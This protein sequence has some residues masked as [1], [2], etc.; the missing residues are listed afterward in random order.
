MSLSC[1]QPRMN[2]GTGPGRCR[3]GPGMQEPPGGALLELRCFGEALA[4]VTQVVGV[5]SHDRRFAG[6]IP[7][8]GTCLGCGF[9]P[10]S[11]GI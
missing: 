7:G 8:Q 6:L 1:P 2:T 3:H 4:S 11:G 9:D 10:W 5:S